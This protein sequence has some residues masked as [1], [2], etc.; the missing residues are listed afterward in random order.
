MSSADSNNEQPIAAFVG[1]DWADQKNDIVLRAATNN[2]GLEHRSIGSEPAAL[3]EWVLEVRERF[4]SLGKIVVCLEQ[5][6]GALIHFLMGYDCF[7][8]YP[9]NPNQLASYREA[10][11]P[12]GAKDDPIDAELLCQFVSLHHPNL[13]P[14]RP[15]DELTRKLA[16][17]CEK[18][19]QAVDARTALSNQLK[20]ELKQYYP[21]ALS[22]LDNDLTTTLAAD[23][24]LQWP[25]L[26]S[27]K[28][29]A[30]HKLRKF[31]YGHQSRSEQKLQGRL[32]RIQAAQALTRDPAIIEA[33]SLTVQMLAQQLKALVPYIARYEKEIAQLFELHPDSALFNNLPGAGPTLGPRLLTAFGTDRERFQS[34][35][36]AV[37]F[38]GLAP[39]TAQSGQSRWIHFRWACPKFLRQSFHEFAGQSVRFCDWAAVYYQQQRARGKGHHA[40]IRALA[41]KWI[42]ILFRCW[43]THQPYDPQFYLTALLRR[44]SPYTPL[45]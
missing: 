42:R 23:F 34:S 2:A 32:E 16:L 38:F 10:L 36:E 37:T 4:A 13:R 27:L 35:L 11:R 19:R 15:D 1:I 6:R 20:S 24:L 3:A 14:W 12:S 9:I 21:L 31:F 44:G 43:K 5:S 41:Y 7:E 22:V 40:A 8:L 39:V 28:K 30:P 45:R 18:R 26:E 33:G 25:N 29:S 17:L